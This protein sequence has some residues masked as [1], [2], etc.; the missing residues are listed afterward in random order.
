MQTVDRIKDSV[1][2]IAEEYGVKR[3]YLFGSYAKGNADEHSDVDILI[4]KGAPLSL[5]GLSGMRQSLQEVLDLPVD[6]ITTSG[7]DKDFYDSIRGSE[8]LI[9]ER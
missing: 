4:E 8:V 1:K 3:V 7:V 5:I 2:P 6:L 9:Y